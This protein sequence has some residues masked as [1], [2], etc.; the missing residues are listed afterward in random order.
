[1]YAF[2]AGKGVA[3]DGVAGMKLKA[4]GREGGS[5]GARGFRRG[6]STSLKCWGCGGVTGASFCGLSGSISIATSLTTMIDPDGGAISDASD[7]LV[8]WLTTRTEEFWCGYNWTALASAISGAVQLVSIEAA[9]NGV[10]R[11][12]Y[13]R[14][15]MVSSG[16]SILK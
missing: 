5:G 6:E 13:F 15:D 7:G 12:E 9:E 1:M 3:P 10:F 2:F 4:G 16:C 11:E 8:E 14:E